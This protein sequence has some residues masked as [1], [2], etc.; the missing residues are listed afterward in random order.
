MCFAAGAH[1]LSC[2][3][4]ATTDFSKLFR[5]L[6]KSCSASSAKPA[7]TYNAES[8]FAGDSPDESKRYEYTLPDLGTLLGTPHAQPAAI[9]DQ[10]TAPRMQQMLRVQRHAVQDHG[11]SFQATLETL[12]DELFDVGASLLSDDAILYTQHL[13]GGP[14]I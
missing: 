7:R 6:L 10:L 14:Y 9:F 8:A 2:H 12:S 11:D 4:H 1:L 5:P 3:A 13:M